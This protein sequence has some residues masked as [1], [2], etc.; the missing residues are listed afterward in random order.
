MISPSSVGFCCS[1]V[2]LAYNR[3]LLHFSSLLH[4]S[5]TVAVESRACAG[6]NGRKCPIQTGPAVGVSMP[7]F[8][9]VVSGRDASAPRPER[10]LLSPAVTRIGMASESW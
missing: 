9:T 2:I 7:H 3:A 4:I 1:T 5:K 8:S 10:S 6:T